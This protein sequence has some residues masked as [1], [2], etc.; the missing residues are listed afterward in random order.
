MH[1]FSYHVILN[2]L[3]SLCAYTMAHSPPWAKFWLLVTQVLRT[4]ELL[5]PNQEIDTGAFCKILP[6]MS[7]TTFKMAGH[8]DIP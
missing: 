4:N 5:G 7:P 3:P 6:I 1:T 8:I 2:H